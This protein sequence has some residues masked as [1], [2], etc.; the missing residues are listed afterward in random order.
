M[1]DPSTKQRWAHQRGRC[2]VWCCAMHQVLFRGAAAPLESI[3]VGASRIA[4]PPDLPADIEWPV[5]GQRRLPLVLQLAL[6]DVA[7]F[8]AASRLPGEGTLWFFAAQLADWPDAPHMIDIPAAV[9]WAPSDAELAR[10]T[11]PP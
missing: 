2:G 11:P 3:A 8:P 5:F 1:V 6:A 10:A 9:R 7:V 4:G